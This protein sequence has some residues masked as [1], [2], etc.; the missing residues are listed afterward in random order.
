MITTPQQDAVNFDIINV[1]LPRTQNLQQVLI[2]QG[3][4]SGIEAMAGLSQP[5][6]TA[7]IQQIDL[8]GDWLSLGGIDCLRF[9]RYS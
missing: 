9:S 3:K 8:Q 5:R 1:R 6:S 7:A 2:R 4:I